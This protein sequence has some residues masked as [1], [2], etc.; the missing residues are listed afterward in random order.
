MS[1][2]VFNLQLQNPIDSVLVRICTLFIRT[3][4]QSQGQNSKKA[5]YF[6]DF[7]RHKIKK[8][9]SKKDIRFSNLFLILFS[10]SCTKW[11]TMSIASM[12]YSGL[13]FMTAFTQ[14]PDFST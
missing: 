11:A 14:P 9:N 3:N 4:R 6:K 1:L 5:N 2:A 12:T 10:N 13:P 7:C 8:T